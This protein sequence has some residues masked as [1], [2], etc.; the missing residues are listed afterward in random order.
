[1]VFDQQALSAPERTAIVEGDR[2]W[3][4]G[5][6]KA[7][8][9]ML[10]QYVLHC[11]AGRNA[12]V[13]VLLP[14]GFTLV[15]SLLAIFRAGQIYL[16]VDA[17][18]P[19]RRLHAIFEQTRPAVCITTASLAAVAEG[20]ISKQAAY[21]CRLIVLDGSQAP[22]V[23]HF[24]NST[25]LAETAL[26]N[27]P[28]MD[29][30]EVRPEDAN[31][32]FYTS[33]STGEA[34][35]ILGCHDSLSHFIHWEIREFQLDQQCRVSQLS[36]FTFD[37]SLRDILVP[38][39]TGGTLCFP[40]A[41]NRNNMPALIAWLE[42][43]QVTLMHCVPSVFRLITRELMAEGEQGNKVRLPCLRHVLM[44]GEPLYGKDIL[45]WRSTGAGHVE[46]VNLYGTSETTMAKTFHRIADAPYDAAQPVHAGKP[47]SNALIAVVNNGQLCRPGEIG[48]I[49]IITPFMT[50]G[51]YKNEVLTRSVFVQNPLVKDR[52]EI[53]Y[54]TGDYGM[55]LEDGSLEVLGRRDEQVKINGIR[56]EL[57]EIRQAI[58]RVPGV[59]NTEIIAVKNAAE[60]N[61][62]IC[63]YI[64]AKE[65]D[66]TLRTHVTVELGHHLVP[67]AFIRLDEFPLTIN[68]KVDKK[69]LPKPDRIVITDEAYVSPATL[70]EEKLE[71][72][73]KDLLG[74]VRVG[75]AVNF[76]KVGGSSLKLIKMVSQIFHEL[77]V[78]IAFADV[79]ANNTIRQL[80][81]FIDTAVQAGATTII[82]LPARAYYD[83]TPAQRR[84]WIYDKTSGQ[85]HLYN[86]VHAVTL[87]GDIRPAALEQ[88]LAALMARHEILRTTFLNVGG[89]PRQRIHPAGKITTPFTYLD[90]QQHLQLYGGVPSI[91]HA[92]QQR[93]FD[94]ETGP[95]FFATLV[96]MA[97]DRYCLIFNWHHIIA[98]GWTQDVLLNDLLRLYR[99]SRDQQEQALNPLRFQYRDYA[100]WANKQLEGKRLEDLERYWISRFAKPFVP[101]TF[102]AER[103]RN[104]IRAGQGASRDFLL[105]KEITDQLHA[106]TQLSATTSFMVLHAIVNILLYRYTGN[107][108]IVTG[109]PFSGRANPELQDQAGLYVNLLPLRMTIAEEDSFLAVLGS[110]RECIIGAHQHQDYP[111]DMLVQRLSL[112]TRNGRMPMFNVLVQSQNNLECPL[113]PPDGI[114]VRQMALSAATSK[115]D[116]TFNFQERGKEILASVEYDTELYSEKAMAA[117]VENFIRA[118]RQLTALPGTL[119][120]EVTI[121]RAA[122]E[123]EEEKDFINMLQQL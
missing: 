86:I 59:T 8:S 42:Q 1:M 115:A 78:S 30:P 74:L 107:P 5:E 69:A 36:Q 92:E 109:T 11:N 52:E 101:A 31:Y 120:K 50:K 122:G 110:T 35:A 49:Y 63:Y 71:A 75:T 12:P 41:D 56:V 62:L 105:D 65:M 48:E 40:P 17:A 99:A 108:D 76:F 44:A 6:L 95:L 118:A 7:G 106:L 2:T 96:E 119:V 94:L 13:A 18:L 26:T 14:P 39:C 24:E 51:Y 25:C 79:F 67:S 16:P 47:I 38:L 55:Y 103:E 3:S 64:A 37:A 73:W 91:I 123:A 93:R 23:R 43:Q 68:G 113:V 20:I 111:I 83:V 34:K 82:P 112:E 84:L 32:I 66:D 57:G 21:A 90:R 46:L 53:V 22:L 114:A 28:A 54:R 27:L 19:A 77:N 121:T 15:S 4:Y 89:E 117:I 10:A 33:G 88:A 80:G 70:T 116:V 29:L 81:A 100:E 45:N 102:P 104:A 98:D 9:E 87:E 61:E 60:E 72:I 58:L 85:Q 97:E